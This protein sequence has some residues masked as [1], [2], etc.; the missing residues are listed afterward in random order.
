MIEVENVEYCLKIFV[1]T[2]GLFIKLQFLTRFSRMV[3]LN[4]KIVLLK[5]WWTLCW[6]VLV[7]LRICVWGEAFLS[8]N[9]ILNKLPHKN[10]I[11]T[12]Y[13]LWKCHKSSYKYFKVWRCLTK[14]RVSR[15]KQVKIGQKTV[16]WIFIVYTNKSSI[17]L[18]GSSY[19]SLTLRMY[20]KIIFL[21]LGIVYFLR[22]FSL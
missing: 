3:L 20:I 9:H 4:V 6:L 19:I 22:I 2:L 12:L 16:D 11:K 21:D 10:R 7:Y 18:I 8:A 17:M 13:E 1:S 15:P 5:I 14:I